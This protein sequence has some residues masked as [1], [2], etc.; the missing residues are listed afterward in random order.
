V[1]LLKIIRNSALHLANVIEDVLEMSRIENG[2][3]SINEELFNLREAI[4]TVCKIMEFQL[5]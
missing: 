4:D 3:F 2:K 5:S 1:K